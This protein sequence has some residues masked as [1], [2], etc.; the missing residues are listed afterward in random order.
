[1]KHVRQILGVSLFVVL[2]I[3]LWNISSTQMELPANPPQLV[4][5][6]AHYNL[7]AAT[8]RQEQLLANLEQALNDEAFR[9]QALELVNASVQE[10]GIP[11]V[12]FVPQPRR[13]DTQ[14]PW[15]KRLIAAISCTGNRR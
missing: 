14:Q 9:L 3:V 5:A 11:G 4:R 15:Y 6:N 8:E 7:D 10:L 2:C 1:M 12:L 13:A